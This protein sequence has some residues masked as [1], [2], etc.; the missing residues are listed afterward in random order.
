MLDGKGESWYIERTF[1]DKSQLNYQK[2]KYY[3]IEV[4][5]LMTTAFLNEAE[6]NEDKED[7]LAKESVVAQQ[8]DPTDYSLPCELLIFWD[9]IGIMQRYLKFGAAKHNLM[10]IAHIAHRNIAQNYIG[11]GSPY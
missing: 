2:R 6:L 4:V 9:P 7:L 3:S 10:D 8:D 5:A 11:I 1:R